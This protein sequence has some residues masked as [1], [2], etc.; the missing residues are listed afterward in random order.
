MNLPYCINL[1][2]ESGKEMNVAY[3]WPVCIWIRNISIFKCILCTLWRKQYILFTWKVIKDVYDGWNELDLFFCEMP[4]AH[5][6]W[7]LALDMQCTVADPGPGN[8]GHLPGLQQA[9]VHCII[10]CQRHEAIAH[11]T[12]RL[13]IVVFAQAQQRF[14]VGHW[15]CRCWLCSNM[16]TSVI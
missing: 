6:I 4:W 7:S 2:P 3:I 10:S 16:N 13:Q 8:P 14:W 15:Q 1:T 9:E 5:E 11:S 12:P